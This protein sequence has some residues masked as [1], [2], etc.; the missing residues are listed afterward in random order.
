MT[1]ENEPL[2]KAAL[3]SRILELE[4]AAYGDATVRILGPVEQIKHLHAA[5]A[6]QMSRAD[7]LNRLCREHRARIAELEK[8]S[9][10]L[11][12]LEAAGV[13]NWEG[14]SNAFAEGDEDD[15]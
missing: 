8:D 9:A 3:Y 15:D 14:Y 4:A 13:D 10:R 1:E 12:A 11:A 5:L 2:W 7:T 6:A